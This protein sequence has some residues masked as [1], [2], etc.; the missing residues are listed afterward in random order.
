M[1]QWIEAYENKSGYTREEMT[2]GREKITSPEG[3]VFFVRTLEKPKDPAIKEIHDLMIEEFGEGEAEDLEWIR[4]SIKEKLND[5]HVIESSDGKLIGFT[6]SQYLE[7]EPK[8]RKEYPHTSASEYLEMEP[9]LGNEQE[10]AK[11]SFVFL[12]YV[13]TAEE[14]RGKGIGT[15]LYRKFYEDSLKKASANGHEIKGVIDEAV[16]SVE[17]FTNKMGR[18]RMYFEDRS[19][20]IIEVP[21]MCPPVNMDSET[22]KPPEGEQGEAYPEH[23]MIGLTNG[24]KELN[25]EDVLRMVKRIYMEYVADEENYNSKEAFQTAW[26]HDMVILKEL[27]KSLLKAKDGRI[28]LMSADEREVKKTELA[29]QGKKL[30]EVETEE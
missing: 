15:E 16:S 30:I 1:P 9:K 7:L 20:N 21:Y 3:E 5:Y 11:E 17:V 2:D 13:V 29:S 10:G 8:P 19:G 22:G 28:F 25:A 6:N 27:E 14:A 4:T 23:L 26:D 12:C 24:A 18:D